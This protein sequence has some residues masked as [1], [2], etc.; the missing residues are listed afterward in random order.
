MKFK[1]IAAAALFTATAAANAQD[2]PTTGSATAAY[3]LPTGTQLEYVTTGSMK[4]TGAFQREEQV[5]L[6]SRYTVLDKR[7][8]GQTLLAEL[9]VATGQGETTG[10]QQRKYEPAA[11]FTFLLPPE[12]TAPGEDLQT[13][14]FSGSPFPGWRVENLF[15][16]IPEEGTTSA[17]LP[18]ATLNTTLE[19]VRRVQREGKN[20][21]ILVEAPS[22]ATD[23]DGGIRYY[24]EKTEYVGAENSVSMTS[25]SL[26]AS[27]KV[28]N[29]PGG[30]LSLESSTRRT[31][32]KQ[33]PQQETAALKK[34][35]E[36]AVPLSMRLRS[37]SAQDEGSVKEALRMIDDYLKEHPKGVFT[38]L[39][40]SIR[41]RLNMMTSLQS[42]SS[43]IKEGEK[44]PGFEVTTVDGK[45][46]KLN[47]YAGK[48]V[49]LDFWATWCGPCV[50]ELPNVKKL[51]ESNKGKPF[52]IIGFSADNELSDLTEFIKENG[53]T[54]PNVFEPD[55]KPGTAML[56]Y[57]VQKYPT[58][59]LIDGKGI[60]RHVDLRGEEL[61]KAVDELLTEQK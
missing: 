43:K 5:E 36:V 59:V 50:A 10:S 8:E 17:S 12:G 48:V 15:P 9:D 20:A 29:G 1:A 6:R 39:Y 61:E 25:T 46:I 54:W 13:A 23:E 38:P 52:E 40:S 30:D 56:T 4:A 35:V 31:G 24:G 47:D 19:V 41:E 51:Y 55:P 60:I 26:H 37:L 49:L 53:I 16:Q 3:D 34:E 11:R 45:K 2:K 28:P 33:L 32:Q 57:G 27:M 58:T 14:G 22:T 44:A 18:L 42:N 7:P 21:T